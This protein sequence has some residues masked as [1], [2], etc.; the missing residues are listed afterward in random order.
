MI[1]GVIISILKKHCDTRG[2]LTEIYRDD[3]LPEGFRPA[4][5]YISA[6]YPNQSRGPHEHKRQTDYFSFIGDGIFLLKLWDNRTESP[7]YKETVETHINNCSVLIPAG[8]VH[9]YK[10]VSDSMAFCINYPDALYKG[11]DKKDEVDEIRYED[12]DSPFKI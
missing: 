3:E 7:T 4:M 8:V 10:N 11:V 5:C 6:T 1:Q 9:A 2:W 12:T